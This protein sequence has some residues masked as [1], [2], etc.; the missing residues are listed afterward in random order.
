MPVSEGPA[1]Q[2]APGDAAQ[3]RATA[4]DDAAQAIE[5]EVA[6]SD[7]SP[8]APADDDYAIP[9]SFTFVAPKS[10]ARERSAMAA[11]APRKS[12]EHEQQDADADLLAGRDDFL[13]EDA[14]RDLVADIVRQELQGALGERI[15]RNVRKLVRREIHRALASQEL[16]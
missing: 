1:A 13:D 3:G 10:P 15:T 7:K 14:L 12:A 2:D 16:D 11:S 4:D 9:D 5:D 8:E 6:K